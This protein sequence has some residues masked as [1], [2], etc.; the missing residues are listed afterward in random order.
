MVDAKE[1]NLCKS[2]ER[3]LNVSFEPIGMPGLKGKY[4]GPD[5][6]KASG[7]AAGNKKK[8]VK[9]DK[10]ETKK[11]KVKIRERDKK[12]IGNRR[13]PSVLKN[14]LNDGFAPPKKKINKNPDDAGDE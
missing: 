3:Y 12:N 9:D 2:I 10:V 14:T 13:I 1:W 8:P 5:K 6:V 4:Q 11:P 7:K